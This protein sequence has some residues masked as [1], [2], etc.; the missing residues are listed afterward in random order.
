MIFRMVMAVLSAA[1]SAVNLTVY[2]DEDGG[3]MNLFVGIFCGFVCLIFTAFPASQKRNL[4]GG[5]R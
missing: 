5:A 1:G 4:T 2:I 3:A